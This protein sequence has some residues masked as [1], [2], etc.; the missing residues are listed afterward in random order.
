MGGLW[1]DYERTADGFLAE[2]HP[3]NQAT[4]I[5]GLY[6]AGECEYQYHGANRLG[7][8]ALVACIYAGKIGG[9]AMVAHARQVAKSPDAVSSSLI[10]A[11]V[12]RW[13]ERFAAIRRMDGGENPYRLHQELGEMMNEHVTIVRWNKTLDDVEQRLLE[14]KRRWHD[15]NALDDSE[16]ANPS[17][18]FVN[19]LWN[20]L[21]LSHAIVRGARRRDES[22]GAHYKPEFPQ[23]NDPDWLKTTIASWAP[24][25]PSI[26]YEGVDTTLATP[27]A[28]KYD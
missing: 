20:M 12:G 21:E 3:K 11:A 18:L 6:A 15:V 14:M 19:Q 26:R 5:P 1:V 10:D 4:S 27:V 25:G 13:R 9:P 23:R 24:D 7:A 2:N 22:R 28:R 8:N 17:L 16:W